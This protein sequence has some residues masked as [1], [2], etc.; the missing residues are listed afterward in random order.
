MVE[1]ETK[2]TALSWTLLLDP[3]R[4]PFV[5]R[6]SWAAG[7]LCYPPAAQCQE[8]TRRVFRFRRISES[9]SGNHARF[10]SQALISPAMQCFNMAHRLIQARSSAGRPRRAGRATQPLT[11][12]A[13]QNDAK[14]QSEGSCV[15]R[16][17]G[18]SELVDRTPCLFK[19]C[20]VDCASDRR[21]SCIP[22]S[23]R[24]SLLRRGL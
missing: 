12:D 24:A 5:Q 21:L 4:S 16:E 22:P 17:S 18:K 10:R 19:S 1:P 13:D 9:F 8:K 23:F 6:P 3:Q 2:R 14:S 15:L 20:V 7:F 11:V